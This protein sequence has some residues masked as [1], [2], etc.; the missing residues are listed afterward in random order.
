M[1][2][3]EDI[4]QIHQNLRVGPIVS[5]CPISGQ[6]RNHLIKTVN[7]LLTFQCVIGLDQWEKG[8]G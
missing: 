3:H 6:V 5:V 8:G 2:T 1:L 4:K 7:I